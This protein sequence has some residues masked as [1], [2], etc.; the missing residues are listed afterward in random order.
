LSK[1]DAPQMH[2]LR[3]NEEIMK[4]ISRP[5]TKSIEEAVQLIEI[6][7][8]RIDQTEGINWGITL[9][10]AD[11]LIGYIGYV[12]IHKDNYRAEIGYLL[13]TAFHRQG[14]MNEALTAVL[15]FG[16]N[17][18]DLHSV[19]AIISPANKA[20]ASL[21]EKNNFIKEAYFKEDFYFEGNFLDSEVYSLL[22]KS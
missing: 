3:S 15:D 10:P 21:L 7:N 18:L 17:Q 12:Q 22:K 9:K 8:D 16:F 20:S 4:Y 2:L 14:I 11:Q 13:H 5:R 1:E 6:I 19:E